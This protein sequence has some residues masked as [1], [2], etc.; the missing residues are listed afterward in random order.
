M[1]GSKLVDEREQKQDTRQERPPRIRTERSPAPRRRRVSPC[2]R[3]RTGTR[4]R[5]TSRTCQKSI[6]KTTRVTSSRVSIEP[7]QANRRQSREARTI[8]PQHE[9][10][11]WKAG[12]QQHELGSAAGQQTHRSPERKAGGNSQDAVASQRLHVARPE[13]GQPAASERPRQAGATNRELA[14]AHHVHASADHENGET[15][16]GILM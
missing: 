8:Y 6:G 14:R 12:T 1:H 2:P 10:V 7:E 16:R 4:A 3:L 5:G 15:H 9:Q 13:Q 11:A